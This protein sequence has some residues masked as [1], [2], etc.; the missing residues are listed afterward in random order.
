MIMCG[1]LR[2]KSRE[3][4]AQNKGG[5]DCPGPPIFVDDIFGLLPSDCS[6]VFAAAGAIQPDAGLTARTRR[7]RASR[8]AQSH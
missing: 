3:F 6:S 2:A 5:P 1:R 8:I 7:L 4:L